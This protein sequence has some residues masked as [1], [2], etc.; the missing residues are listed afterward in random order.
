MFPESQMSPAVEVT[1]SAVGV[2]LAIESNHRLLFHLKEFLIYCL[3]DKHLWQIQNTQ[4]TYCVFY[5][6]LRTFSEEILVYYMLF[7]GLLTNNS[8]NSLFKS[9]IL[10]SN[11]CYSV[12]NTFPHIN[13]FWRLC[14]RRLFENILTKEEIVQNEQFLNLT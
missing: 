12:F 1:V 3:I 8:E 14:S 6:L 13:A 9:T 2:Y 5:I 4:C 10:S 11:S 7:A